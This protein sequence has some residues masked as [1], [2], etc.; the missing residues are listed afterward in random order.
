MFYIICKNF[1]LYT[2]S[3]FQIYLIVK[4]KFIP[5]TEI[6]FIAVTYFYYF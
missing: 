5:E 6:F 4:L 3:H 1:N 2:S